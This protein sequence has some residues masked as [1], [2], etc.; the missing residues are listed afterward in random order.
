MNESDFAGDAK[1]DSSDSVDPRQLLEVIAREEKLLAC[2]LHDDLMQ[3]LVG[4]KM[5]VESILSQEES[6]SNKSRE[7]MADVSGC[8]A[9]SI[10]QLRGL[11]RK[12]ATARVEQG[13]LLGELE[14][15]IEN[16]RKENWSVECSLDDSLNDADPLQAGSIYRIVKE[17]IQNARKHSGASQLYVEVLKSSNDW[18]I[19]VLDN[20]R[21]LVSKDLVAGEGLGINGIRSRATLFDGQLQLTSSQLNAGSFR[22][23]V[24]RLE[25]ELA[26]RFSSGTC[27]EV[28]FPAE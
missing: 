28:S 22:Q 4:S 23:K 7:K 8:L 20:G 1:N 19:L 18:L 5:Q 25:P 24:A 10:V 15:L 14:Q 21:G 12:L 9:E 11:I 2:D 16:T 17:A 6:L 27:L 3:L 26:G 13:F